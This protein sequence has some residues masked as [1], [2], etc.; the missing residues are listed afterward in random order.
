MLQEIEVAVTRA[1]VTGM[2]L[3]PMS[4]RTTYTGIVKA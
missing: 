4:D 3:G 2:E 1:N